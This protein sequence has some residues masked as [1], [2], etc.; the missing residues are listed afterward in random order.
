MIYIVIVALWA[1][2]LIPMWLRRHDRISE[3]RSTKRFNTAMASLSSDAHPVVR[4]SSVSQRSRTGTNP[5]S[6]ESLDNL[7]NHEARELQPTA[8]RNAARARAARRRMV[9]MMLLG[10]MTAATLG[11]SL[12]SMVPLFVPIIAAALALTFIIA[13]A[14][15]ASSRTSAEG[16]LLVND[17]R[18]GESVEMQQDRAPGSPAPRV[19]AVAPPTRLDKEREWRRREALD[20]YLETPRAVGQ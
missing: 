7:A 4:N 2:L 6:R 5:L 18:V 19:V 14:V 9:V 12:I 8:G 17:V 1:A 3:V 13:G 20:D 16:S 15:T 10:M 11:L